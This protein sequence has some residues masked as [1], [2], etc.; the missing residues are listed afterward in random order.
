MHS[1]SLRDVAAHAIRRARRH[2]A[3]DGRRRSSPPTFSATR[4]TAC[5]LLA[6]Y[7]AEIEK[8][9]MTKAG[10]PTVVNARAASETWD[11]QRLPG[12]WLT[13]RAL[14]RAAAMA[15]TNG[16]GTIVIRRSHHIACLA[17]YLLR[18]TERGL[19][20]IVQSSDPTVVRGGSSWRHHAGH[21]AESDRRRLADVGRSDPDRHLELDHEHGVRVSAEE[22]GQE[23]ARRV[24]RS[25][26]RA[27]RPTIPLRF[28]PIPA[29]RCCRWAG[30]TPA[31]RASG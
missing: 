11:G 25:T 22:R 9:A 24:A 21:H 10:E 19:V 12:T 4:R 30:S 14:D 13:L 6:P 3:R 8:G 31:T 5:A 26:T 2:R 29:A 7:L 27:T 15:K 16:T 28:P 17:V 18:A 1:S 20:A 23:A